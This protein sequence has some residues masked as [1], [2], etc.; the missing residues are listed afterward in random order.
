MDDV[1]HFALKEGI[2][3]DIQLNCRFCL[4]R[5]KLHHVQWGVHSGKC[6][7]D[8]SIKTSLIEI[9]YIKE[10]AHLELAVPALMATMQSVRTTS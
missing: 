6:A 7:Y 5:S 10:S 9:N 2:Q 3:N 8:C 1:F 4:L